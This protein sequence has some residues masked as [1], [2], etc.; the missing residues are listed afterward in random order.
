VAFRLLQPS[1]FTAALPWVEGGQ[2]LAVAAGVAVSSDGTRVYVACSCGGPGSDDDGVAVLDATT[3]RLVAGPVALRRAQFVS[4]SPDGALVFVAYNLQG[5]DWEDYGYV[6]VIDAATLKLRPVSVP[7]GSRPVGI[8]TAP[9][10]SAC[11]RMR[12][13]RDRDDRS[14]R[15]HPRRLRHVPPSALQAIHPQRPSAAAGGRQDEI[16]RTRR[17][18]APPHARVIAP[19]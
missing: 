5:D 19:V 17:E 18:P 12:R 1:S 8:A 16:S 14:I 6:A 2:A 15:R 3:L 13:R 10:G 7:I 4:V 11:V 9:D